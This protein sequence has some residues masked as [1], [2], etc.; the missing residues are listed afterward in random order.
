MSHAAKG[1]P[2]PWWLL[3]VL[4][5]TVTVICLGGYHSYTAQRNAVEQEVTRELETVAEL[6]VEQISA[7]R[8]ERLADAQVLTSDAALMASIES[9]ASGRASLRARQDTLLRL[10]SFCSA[11][12]YANAVILDAEGKVALLHGASFGGGDHFKALLAAAAAQKGAFLR[13]LHS[14]GEG[15]YHFG[16]NIPLRL[17]GSTPLIGMLSFAITPERYLFPMPDRRARPGQAGKVFLV[18]RN[19]DEVLVFAAPD[20][21]GNASARIRLP[22]SQRDAI[23]VNA[24]SGTDGLI[25]GMDLLRRP[26]IAVVLALPDSQWLVVAQLP[27]EFLDGPI[28]DRAKPVALTV[29]A[30]ILAAGMTGAYLWRLQERKY[31]EARRDAEME[32]RA[33]LAHY[34]YLSRSA[35]DAIL[36]MDEKGRIVEANERALTMYGYSRAELLGMNAEALDAM[37]APHRLAECRGKSNDQTEVLFEAVQARKD[38]STF[39]VEISTLSIEI[40]GVTYH[41]AIIRDIT[42]RNRA[43]RQLENAN[44]LY[45]V[46]SQCSQAIFRAATEQEL[47]DGVCEAAVQE[48]GF[49]LAAVARVELE[50]KDVHPVASAGPSKEYLT[51]IELSARLDAY[52]QGTI[53][54][55]LRTDATTVSEDIEHDPRMAAWKER[56]EQWRLRSLICVPVRRGQQGEFAFVLYSNETSFFNPPEIRLVEEIGAKIS[57]A[58][59]RLDEESGRKAAEEALLQSE[60]RYRRLVESAPLGL[61]VHRNGLVKYM[62]PAGLRMLGA[63]S[64]DTVV[65]AA[66]LK[67]IH[68]DDHGLV[69]ERIRRLQAGEPAP[70]IEERFVRIDRS[71]FHV[72]VSAV[73][74]Q[75]DGQDAIFVFFIDATQRKAAEADRA[76]MEEQFLQSQKMESVGRLAGGV[77]HDFNNNLTVINGY[78][79]L[80]LSSLSAGD[81]IRAQLSLIRKAGDQASR[82]TRQLLTFSH[83][84]V[85]SPQ[86]VDLNEAVTEAKSLFDRLIGEQ[87]QIYTRLDPSLPCVLADPTQMNQ[88]LMNLAINARDAMPNGGQLV[89]ATESVHLR[90]EHATRIAGARSGHF[91]ALTVSDTGVGMDAETQ[92][93]IFEPF[94]TTKPRGTG[95]GLGLATVYGIVQQSKGWVEVTSEPGLG[96]TFRILLPAV[97]GVITAN[98]EPSSQDV[99]GHGTV[100]LVE[101]QDDVRSLTSTILE[102][103]GYSVLEAC[104][105][106]KAL[107]ISAHYQGTINIL[108]T[109]VMMP[110]MSGR[111]LAKRLRGLRTSIKVLLVSGYAGIDAHESGDTGNEFDLLPKPFTHAALAAKVREV[112]KR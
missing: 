68:P 69:T 96:A 24:L 63:T 76:R 95:T 71:I 36:L 10:R 100:L 3:A 103:L 73:P 49:P 97:T 62:N 18:R 34:S 13:D 52:G 33:L 20:T 65:N 57:Y 99:S 79:D 86:H 82:L 12:Q 29:L 27:L 50:S 92:R 45:A 42:Q 48:G 106:A 93:H 25:R 83:K 88:V 14:E 54:T 40:D 84:Q 91:A 11:Y 55:A 66:L 41:Q 44:R 89:I 7:W 22:L 98:I 4:F 94:F 78:C 59:G 77:A 15:G 108:V 74:I 9:I 105:G 70:L 28:R 8:R 51:G 2:T 23:A 38:G 21:P 26:A 67:F 46:L 104:S 60:V 102:S 37:D 5:A 31:D 39:W 35:H 110:G 85:F 56:A 43:N 81:P 19:G 47:F 6:K 80:L 30:L 87:I 53:G 16:L 58:L 61:Y 72:E 112:L 75:F 101:D 32:N 111:E 64:M 1:N 17:P 107:E 90:K 109:D